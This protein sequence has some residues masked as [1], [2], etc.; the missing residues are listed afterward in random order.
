MRRVCTY[1]AA[2]NV[3]IAGDTGLHLYEPDDLGQSPGSIDSCWAERGENFGHVSVSRIFG[4][5]SVQN[6]GEV[7]KGSIIVGIGSNRMLWLC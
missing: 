3:I 4:C 2:K 1:L 6:D 7:E 5:R